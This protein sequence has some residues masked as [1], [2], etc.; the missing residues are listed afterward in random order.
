MQEHHHQQPISLQSDSIQQAIDLEIF[1]M[2]LTFASIRIQIVAIYF[3]VECGTLPM[4]KLL[5]V[6]LQTLW[7]ASFWIHQVQLQV[8]FIR[9]TILLLYTRF[10]KCPLLFLLE[11]FSQVKFLKSWIVS[12]SM[13]LLSQHKWSRNFMLTIKLIHCIQQHLTAHQILNT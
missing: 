11:Y 10:P 8:P 12:I 5:I 9:Q 4:S 3:H 13:Q 6:I 2:S 1:L 7:K